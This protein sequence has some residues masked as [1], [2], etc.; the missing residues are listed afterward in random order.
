MIRSVGNKNQD[1]YY[2]RERAQRAR[3]DCVDVVVVVAADVLLLLLPCAPTTTIYIRT[4][5][6]THQHKQGR[7]CVCMCMTH[8]PSPP[9]PPPVLS[10]DMDGWKRVREREGL[11]VRVYAHAQR[12]RW[13]PG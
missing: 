5:A 9:P 11:C 7:V 3:I 6:R 2:V 4:H 10:C 1:Y 8:S 12:R 13:V